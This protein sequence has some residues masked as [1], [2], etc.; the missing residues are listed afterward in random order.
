MSKLKK[1]LSYSLSDEDIKLYL[2]DIPILEYK[3]LADYQSVEQLLPEQNYSVII[4]IETA[5][6][7]GHWCS[8][9]RRGNTLIWFDSYG[10]DIDAEFRY[11]P[12]KVRQTLHEDKKYLTK[13]VDCSNFDL[14]YNAHRL[15]SRKSFVSTCGRFVVLWLLKFNEGYDLEKFYEY[16]DFVAE[17]LNVKGALKYDLVAFNQVPYFPNS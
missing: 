9:S 8:L 16:L 10:L 4:L 14:V 13:L 2:P 1:M 12:I 15:Q 11:I 17:Q 6:K 5:N 3:D 7:T